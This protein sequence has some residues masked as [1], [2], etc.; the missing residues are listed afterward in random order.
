[1]SSEELEKLKA[2]ILDQYEKRLPKSKKLF[3]EAQKYHIKNRK[4]TG[5]IDRNVTD[6]KLLRKINNPY[7]YDPENPENSRLPDFY[8][9]EKTR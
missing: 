3:D 2:K 7:P 1:M 9:Y 5:W 6:W 8:L 4:F